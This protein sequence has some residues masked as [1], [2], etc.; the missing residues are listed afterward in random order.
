MGPNEWRPNPTPRLEA[1]DSE[2]KKVTLDDYRGKTVVLVFAASAD[3]ASCLSGLA[4]LAEKTGE[5]EKRNAVVVA[6]SP[7]EPELLARVKAERKLLFA[8]LSDPQL[9]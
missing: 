7:E 6:V 9:E 3:C 8:L 5:L 4:K 1:I 2:K